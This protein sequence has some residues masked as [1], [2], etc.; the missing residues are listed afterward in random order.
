VFGRV[1]IVHNDSGLNSGA[2]VTLVVE[3]MVP[4]LFQFEMQIVWV[5]KVAWNYDYVVS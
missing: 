3:C 4:A 2:H 5:L 1:D